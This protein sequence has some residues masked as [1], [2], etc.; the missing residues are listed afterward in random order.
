MVISV[1]TSHFL[2]LN[3][4]VIKTKA[5]MLLSSILVSYRQTQKTTP[6]FGKNVGWTKIADSIYSMNISNKLL[7]LYL[8]EC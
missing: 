6:L 3:H 5:I 4:M 1:S 8:L 7:V 2:Y